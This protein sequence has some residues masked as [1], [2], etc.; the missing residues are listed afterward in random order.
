M[1]EENFESGVIWIG[2][3]PPVF[4]IVLHGSICRHFSDLHFSVTVHIFHLPPHL[5]RHKKQVIDGFYLTII[6]GYERSYQLSR[7]KHGQLWNLPRYQFVYFQR[8]KTL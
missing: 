7:L 3:V 4:R 2:N 6:A 1:K 5:I 8:N